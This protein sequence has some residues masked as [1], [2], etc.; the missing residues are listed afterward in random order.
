M[1]ESGGRMTVIGDPDFT[2]AWLPQPDRKRNQI[3]PARAG[4]DRAPAEKGGCGSPSTTTVPASPRKS[5]TGSSGPL[6]GWKTPQPQDRG[7]DQPGHRQEGHDRRRHHPPARSPAAGWGHGRWTSPEALSLVRVAQTTCK[8][9]LKPRKW[10]RRRRP[11]SAG[12]AAAR[13]RGAG[14]ATG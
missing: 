14:S 10:E 1:F 9:S 13:R 2:Q 11:S 3:R 7:T 12:T 4:L 6:S 8:T 5:A